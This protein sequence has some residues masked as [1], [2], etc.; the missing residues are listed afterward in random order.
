M[1]STFSK[2]VKHLVLAAAFLALIA[3]YGC[4]D[5]TKTST[6]TRRESTRDSIGVA[7]DSSEVVKP[8]TSVPAT[9]GSDQDTGRGVV[10]P[11]PGVS[12]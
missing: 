9:G 1:T 11:K 4:N 6:E 8:D 5:N 7:T 10:N 3:T 2:T 12:R